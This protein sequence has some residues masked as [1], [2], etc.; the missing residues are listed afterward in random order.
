MSG[1]FAGFV[2]AGGPLLRRPAFLGVAATTLAIGIAALTAALTLVDALLWQEPLSTDAGPVAVYGGIHAA[3]RTVNASTRFIDAMDGLPGVVSQ[4][5][6]MPV[7]TANVVHGDE[8]WLLQT[9]RVDGGFLATL[10]VRPAA[11]SNLGDDEGAMVSYD[12]WQRHLGGRP[13][14]IGSVLVV[15]AQRLPV[16]GILPR[17][18][19]FLGPVD[20]VAPLPPRRFA[21]DYAENLFAVARLPRDGDVAAF[22]RAVQA[23][24]YATA[25]LGRTRGRRMGAMP[26]SDMLTWPA[27]S[28]MLALLASAGVVLGVAGI[29]V[30]S[31]MLGRGLGRARATAIRIALGA[32]DSVAWSM[33]MADAV[34]VGVLG[35]ALGIPLG[36]HFVNVFQEAIPAAWLTS[37]LPIATSGRVQGLAM[38]ASGCIVSLAALG[39][40]PHDRMRDLLRERVAVDPRRATERAAQRARR[41]MI[42]VQTVLASLSLVIGVSAVTRWVRMES[43]SPGFDPGAGVSAELYVDEHTYPARDDVV[44][45][46]DLLG[47]GSRDPAGLAFTTQLPLGPGFVMPFLD[48]HRRVHYVQ[49]VLTTPGAAEAMGLRKTAGRWLESSDR[50]GSPPVALVNQSLLDEMGL[51]PG[52]WLR[53]ASPVAPTAPVRIVGVVADTRTARR[54]ERAVATV[55]LPLTQVD[56]AIFAYIR[57]FLSTYAV[58]R[59]PMAMPDGGLAIGRRLRALTPS[60]AAGEPVTMDQLVRHA[61][62]GARRDA[63]L[64]SALA[65]A[66]LFLAIVGLHSSLSVELTTRRRDLALRLALG[67]G[68]HRLVG[69]VVAAHLALAVIGTALGLLGAS[70]TPGGRFAEDLHVDTLAIAAGLFLLAA[71]SASAI[72]AWRAASVHP[73]GVL[74]G[75]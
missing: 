19:R 66:A 57:P 67:A 9:Q 30:S 58:W 74:R 54:T 56:P 72:P 2:D 71:L 60:L 21:P 45:L 28:A 63:A 48:V 34:A 53:P 6:A 55:L 44:R 68:R 49:Y 43:A 52:G 42:L 39:A 33:A 65:L 59:R 38:L 12:F 70:F 62:S 4:G 69:G 7:R 41:S 16:R 36:A 26:L 17:D 14:A 31:L 8:R 5:L 11:G 18:Y 15:D 27:R 24:A 73:A 32:N 13:D 50:A 61:R 37:P 25:L 51:R 47:A 20:V 64:Y 22:S 35:A 29:N 10:G 46:L 1:W 3:D 23:R 40:T 75:G